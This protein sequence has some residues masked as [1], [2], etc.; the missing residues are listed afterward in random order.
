MDQQN[1]QRIEAYL[2]R[3]FRY[4]LC[5]AETRDLA[6]D[7]VQDCAVRALAA[8]RVP[9][10]EPAYRAWLFRILRNAH[11]DRLR[12]RNGEMPAGDQVE[13]I[14]ESWQVWTCN[15]AMISALTVKLGLAK[16]RP[17][18]REIIALIDIA[19]LSYREAA[20]V[21]DLPC[22]T[23]MSRLSRARQ[24]LMAVVAD[25]NVQPLPVDRRRQAK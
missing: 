2:D 22:G 21:L 17:P 8:R 16:L 14:T 24:A 1:R 4:S 11:I 18:Q 3:L 25:S 10:D 6:R 23:V 20:H 15:E 13:P 7:L 19:G 5:L 12:R 9:V